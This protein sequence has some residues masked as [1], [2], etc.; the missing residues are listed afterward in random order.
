MS[1]GP[2]TPHAD[3]RVSLRQ[4]LRDGLPSAIKARDRLAVAALRS[5]LAAIDNA[6][7]VHRAPTAHERMGIEQIPTG[8]GATE[9][10]RR[11]LTPAQVAHIVRAEVA[12]R[13]AAARDYDLAGRP[14]RARQLRGEA[15]VLLA[16]LAEP[17]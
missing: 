8:V 7:A 13:E 11:V 6:E 15:R 3:P 14:E 1:T 4:R 12:E 5:T 9:V 10:D 2:V 16:H 17:E